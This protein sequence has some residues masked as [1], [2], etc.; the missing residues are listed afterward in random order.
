[1]RTIDEIR[2]IRDLSF[3]RDHPLMAEVETPVHAWPTFGEPVGAG[4]VP[5]MVRRLVIALGAMF[6]L[7][8]CTSASGD[9]TTTVGV[10]PEPPTTTTAAPS[11]T[12]ST[13][14]AETLDTQI[15]W[16]VAVL[17][18]EPVDDAEVERR[19]SRVLLEYVPAS[20]FLEIVGELR[21]TV[22]GTWTAATR[23]NA[24][25]GA[26][27]DLATDD[28]PWTMAIS[29][30][31]S[32]QI[33]TLLLQPAV[34]E[35]SDPPESLV[36]LAD[37]LA[38]FGRVSLQVSEVTTG[39]C[40]PLFGAG[41][42]VVRPI[43]STFKL[44]VLAA[45]ADA[46]A[47]G[48][49]A[50]DDELAIRDDLKSLPS[51]TFQTR[52][53]GSTATV[54]EFAEAMIATS[55]NT[56]TDH[57]MDLVGRDAVET[58]L[59]DYGNRHGDRNRPFLS[60]REMFALKLTAPD[61][62]VDAWLGGDEADRRALLE[63]AVAGLDVGITDAVAWMEP[64]LI[65]EIEWFGDATDQ[66]RVLT[67]LI[68]RSSTPDTSEVRDILSINPGI[69]HDAAIWTYVGFKG[70]SEP[71]VLNLAWY[72]EAA[73]GRAYTYIVNVTNPDTLLPEHEIVALVAT[74]LDLIQG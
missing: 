14:P 8:S 66:C 19:F 68:A 49:V 27:V 64:R 53:D 41:D 32:G 1:M 56:A 33:E 22:S 21:E 31:S 12:T 58:A 47:R 48:D 50:W 72:L 26:T 55:D 25:G 61:D 52:P 60:T 43:G 39:T 42:E 7:A 30:D 20:G 35:V 4:T 3:E 2:A 69:A 18:G 29:V 37:R 6:V 51:G 74:G 73:D 65:D 16:V 5:G 9:S 63:D 40:S 71:G 54:I 45:L 57:L 36:E 13:L 28:G 46:V 38:E 24:P 62:V 10:E 67:G 59:A 34:P 70:G 15:A 44:Y 17:N 11:T 23:S